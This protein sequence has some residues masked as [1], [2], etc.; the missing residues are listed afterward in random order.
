MSIILSTLLQGL[1]YSLLS[2][3][4]KGRIT[5]VEYDSRKITDGSL[6]VA[7]RG[8]TSDGHGFIKTAL[9]N[10]ALCIVADRDRDILPDDEL[11][12]LAQEHSAAVVVTEDTRKAI[13]VLS[14]NFYEHP[15]DRLDLVGVTGTKGKTTVTF[16]LHDILLRDDHGTG[17]MGH[18]M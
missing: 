10:G 5:S 2:G 9:E 6:F 4:L 18:G 14:A 8:F 11:I 7:I 3:D 12:A 13:A 16:M 1:Q 17:L 15:E